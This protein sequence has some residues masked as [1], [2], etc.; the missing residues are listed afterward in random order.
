MHQT[1]EMS[2]S[3][4]TIL[5]GP[6]WTGPVC[7]IRV[8]PVGAIRVKIEAVSTDGQNR[9]TSLVLKRS[10]LAQIRAVSTARPAGLDGDPSGFCLARLEEITL[11][12]LATRYVDLSHL[13]ADQRRSAEA[14]LVHAYIRS[15]FESALERLGGQRCA[16][17]EPGL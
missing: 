1:N 5:T 11:A 9:L 16:R 3:P 10:D 2:I 12:G 7:V 8:D 4:D 14:R 6:F 15:F 13:R 17:A